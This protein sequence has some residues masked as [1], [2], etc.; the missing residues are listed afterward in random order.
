M[1]IW[2]DIWATIVPDFG[3]TTLHEERACREKGQYTPKTLTTQK[4]LIRIS[5][6]I[7]KYRKIDLLEGL[8]QELRPRFELHMRHL[9]LGARSV[10]RDWKSS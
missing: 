2:K 8:L 7:D 4:N 9:S 1:K 3:L 5:F 6:L 10:T